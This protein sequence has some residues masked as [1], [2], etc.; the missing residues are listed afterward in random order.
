MLFYTILCRL[1]ADL[2]S[3]GRE[4]VLWWLVLFCR[5]SFV[6][7]FF[8]SAHH[9]Q[10]CLVRATTCSS[11]CVAWQAHLCFIFGCLVVRSTPTFA[12]FIP[13]ESRCSPGFCCV[14][15]ALLERRTDER[16]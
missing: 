11:S 14:A 8:L 15:F 7:C 5:V 9:T 2:V 1:Y 13:V 10:T 12:C 3:E 16:V 4:F 6:L